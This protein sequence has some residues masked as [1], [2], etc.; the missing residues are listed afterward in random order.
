VESVPTSQSKWASQHYM[1]E[2]FFNTLEAKNTTVIL[3]DH[4]FTPKKFSELV[5]QYKPE[6]E[7]SI[8]LT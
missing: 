3:D 5:F 6:E 7:F 2:S 4:V 8:V 1:K